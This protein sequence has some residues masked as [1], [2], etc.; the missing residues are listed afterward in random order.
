M[1]LT[2]QD[3]SWID[4]IVQERDG[5]GSGVAL[6]NRT[7]MPDLYRIDAS[8]PGGKAQLYHYPNKMD[9]AQDQPC[10]LIAAIN[11]EAIRP[12]LSEWSN[13]ETDLWIV[14]A[15]GH[16]LY[17]ALMR[18]W[19]EEGRIPDLFQG[20]ENQTDSRAGLLRARQSW[21]SGRLSGMFD[22]YALDSGKQRI[23]C[24]L[25]KY[26]DTIG[27]LLE[28]NGYVPTPVSGTRVRYV[29]EID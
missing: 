28:G 24:Y 7:E 29:K 21:E 9:L 14:S 17:H 8:L 4:Q 26:H 18:V 2:N 25:D 3:S 6:Y 11:Y 13:P 15:A 10:Y 23:V 12:E 20:V 16:S 1:S 27:F 5:S 19:Y 22:L